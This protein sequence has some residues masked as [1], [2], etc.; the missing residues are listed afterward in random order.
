MAFEEHHKSVL[1]D[2]FMN[3]DETVVDVWLN[4][5]F[6][7]VIFRERRTGVMGA[8]VGLTRIYQDLPWSGTHSGV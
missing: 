6:P 8:E 4:G 5:R 2:A 7:K 3:C 1:M